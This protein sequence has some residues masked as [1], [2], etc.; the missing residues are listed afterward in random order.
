MSTRQ[1]NTAALGAA[2]EHWRCLDASPFCEGTTTTAAFPTPQ[3]AEFLKYSPGAKT[4]SEGS[5][6]G[7]CTAPARQLDQSVGAAFSALLFMSLLYTLAI[8]DKTNI[9]CQLALSDTSPGTAFNA[10]L[11]QH[12]FTLRECRWQTCVLPNRLF[13]FK[14]KSQNFSECSLYVYK[15]R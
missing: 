14:E 10:N 12:P 5:S 9:V 2:S 15:F 8:V 7:L 13:L 6:V 1:A 3:S 4:S 11:Q